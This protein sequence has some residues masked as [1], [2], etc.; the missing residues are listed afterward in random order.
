MKQN[1]IVIGETYLFVGSDN[2]VR[3]HLAGKPFKVV[4]KR[5]VFRKFKGQVTRKRNR[6]FNDDGVGARA[7]EL[8]PITASSGIVKCDK[9]GY[10]A[11]LG[12][13]AEADSK[14]PE[15]G[16]PVSVPQ[17]GQPLTPEQWPFMNGNTLFNRPDVEF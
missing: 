4:D 7:E 3:A 11:P 1:D 9:C 2:P 5:A 10:V 8:E 16:E 13:I 17:P 15:C 6:F 12:E 14:C